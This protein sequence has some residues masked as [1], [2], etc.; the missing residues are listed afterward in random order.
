MSLACGGEWTVGGAV[1]MSGQRWCSVVSSARATL[2]RWRGYGVP[3][4]SQRRTVLTSTWTICARSSGAR[5]ADYD[6]PEG[7]HGKGERHERRRVP[8]GAMLDEYGGGRLHDRNVRLWADGCA[9]GWAPRPIWAP[10]LNVDVSGNADEPP[11]SNPRR[12]AGNSRDSTR[13]EPGSHA[14]AIVE[15]A[16]RCWCGCR[17]P[18]RKR[19]VQIGVDSLKG[20]YRP[21][22]SNFSRGIPS[23]NSASG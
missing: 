4:E 7:D 2:A 13:A 18:H 1:G 20:R 5:P 19:S 15:P 22:L 10:S 16:G 21:L 12:A 17:R 3:P 11:R 9:Q 6:E 8:A 14:R 23:G